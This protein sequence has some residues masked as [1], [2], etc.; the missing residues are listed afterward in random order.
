MI[1][2]PPITNVSDPTTYSIFDVKKALKGWVL[3]PRT[4]D[5]PPSD[6]ELT[7]PETVIADPPAESFWEPMRYWNVLPLSEEPGSSICVLIP[8]I[9]RVLLFGERDIRVPENVIWDP[10]ARVWEGKMNF[11]KELAVSVI[12]L[13]ATIGGGMESLIDVRGKG[14]DEHLYS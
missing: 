3:P 5:E 12:L 7:I 11:E 6:S 4:T 9:R 13:N 8:P 1:A 10:G 2:G 14:S